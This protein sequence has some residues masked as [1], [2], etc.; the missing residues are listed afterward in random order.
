MFHLNPPPLYFSSA[1]VNYNKSGLLWGFA[2]QEK[3]KMIV[4]KETGEISC[5]R[6]YGLSST[7]I[8]AFFI[9]YLSLF[10]MM[11][12]LRG[13][14]VFKIY[15]NVILHGHLLILRSSQVISEGKFH[16]PWNVPI[17]QIAGNDIIPFH[18]EIC[19]VWPR[20]SWVSEHV[21]HTKWLPW[22]MLA[23]ILNHACYILI[24]GSLLFYLKRNINITQAYADWVFTVDRDGIL[25]DNYQRQKSVS[26]S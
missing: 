13:F 2:D 11:I 19:S 14:A 7:D 9:T 22:F 8:R 15:F 18:F 6:N 10:L 17:F 1:I 20:P 5:S 23:V 16:Y 26:Q 24:F 12:L 21:F 3:L 4:L 25:S